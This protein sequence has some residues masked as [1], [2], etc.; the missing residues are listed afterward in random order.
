MDGQD[1][2]PRRLRI[3]MALIPPL[4]RFLRVADI[5][6]QERACALIFASDKA[7][8][9]VRGSDLEEGPAEGL[10]LWAD[11]VGDPLLALNRTRRIDFAL[12][13]VAA[14]TD[15]ALIHRAPAIVS[16]RDTSTGRISLPH[17]PMTRL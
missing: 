16:R 10:P 14:L 11:H 6:D 17:S 2:Y 1:R 12:F 4:V 3:E 7:W 9:V 8:T 5:G 15:D 13:M